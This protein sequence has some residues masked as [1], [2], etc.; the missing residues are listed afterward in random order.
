MPPQKTDSRLRCNR[1]HIFGWMLGIL[2]Q[3]VRFQLLIPIKLH[4]NRYLITWFLVLNHIELKSTSGFFTWN[5]SSFCYCL[6]CTQSPRGAG[7]HPGC[8]GLKAVLHARQS[9]SHLETNNHHP[10]AQRQFRVPNQLHANGTVSLHCGKK[11]Q[12]LEWT[13]TGTGRT[14]TQKGLG[15]EPNSQPSSHRATLP[16]RTPVLSGQRTQLF[17]LVTEIWI[18]EVMSVSLSAGS[19]CLAGATHSFSLQMLPETNPPIDFGTPPVPMSDRNP[20]APVPHLSRA[21]ESAGLINHKDWWHS[22]FVVIE[23]SHKYLISAG[24]SDSRS[25]PV[26][27]IR[28]SADAG[29]TATA[30]DPHCWVAAMKCGRARSIFLKFWKKKLWI[31]A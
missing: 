5:P 10:P 28:L 12:N 30:A 19:L 21:K 15:W 17:S 27:P 1:V 2:Q 6:T 22:V 16:S 14:S 3:H 7:A 20:S 24:P 25:A 29:G 8:L 11:L 4:N 31:T 23:R 18:T 13:H 9:H 26:C